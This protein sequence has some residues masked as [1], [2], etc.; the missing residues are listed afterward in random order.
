[1]S[2]IK[3]SEEYLL[4]VVKDLGYDIEKVE[5]VP[6]GRKEFGDFQINVA[7]SIAK[8]YHENP[9]AVSEKIV[10]RLDSRF[11]NVN[12]QGAG[13]INLSFSDDVIKNYFNKA[14]DHFDMLYDK[15]DSRKI[16]I[17]YG[18]ANAAKSLHVGHMRSANIG[19]A[20]KRLLR[21]LGMEV[22][23]DVHLGDFGRQ[24][25]MLLSEYKRMYPNSVFFD[26]SYEGEYPKIDLTDKDLGI[27]YPK[28][29]LAANEDP[30]RM[31]EVRNITLQ[32]EKGNRGFVNLWN[33]MVE[34]SSESIKKVYD[35]LNCHFDLWEGEM[36]SFKYI[37]RVLEIMKPYLYESE[38]AL[39]CDVMKEDDNKPMPPLMVI[40]KDGSSIY[41]TRDLGTIL[42]RIERFNPDEIWY[43]TDERQSL[44]FEQVIRASYKTGLVNENV[45][46]KHFGFGTINGSDGKP[47][48]TRDGKVM[49]LAS[50]ISLIKDEIEKNIKDEIK[51]DEREKISDTL[52][53]ATLKYADLLSFR[54][55]DYIFNP[56]EFSSL[57]GKTG[58]YVLYSLV[59]IKSLL[60]KSNS[61]NYSIID[62]S[63]K[64]VSE[65]LIKILE[66]SK[67]LERSYLDA[68][69]NYIEEFIYDVLS[70]YN[71]FY[72]DNNVLNEKDENKKNTYL[73]LS[74]LVYQVI[75]NLLDVLAINE[76]EKM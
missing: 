57:N 51:G 38:G 74:K 17:D 61:D 32:I 13:F 64:E 7:F 33:Q 46:L 70:L 52:S 73:A 21:L 12:I 8:L 14:I 54:K 11:I 60:K 49:D 67:I 35:K 22:I 75:H 15:M 56:K 31:E 65:V 40:K 1:M 47:F 30:S 41:G 43:F 2:L 58:P 36:D 59:R 9:R 45:K 39:V 20:V 26:S 18:G 3:E 71:K 28:A 23:G 5:L 55:T 53:I 4:H 69:L 68:T 48:K 37:P 72:N 66:I 24:A 34:I 50:L 25:G 29:S 10:S 42:G 76:V 6:S 63:N 27:M 16:I 62:L 19:E 44:Y